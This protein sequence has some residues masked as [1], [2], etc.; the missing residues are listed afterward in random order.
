MPQGVRIGTT[1]LK[2]PIEAMAGEVVLL[3]KK[4]GYRDETFA[5]PADHD[6]AQTLTLRK[7]AVPAQPPAGKD[8]FFTKTPAPPSTQTLDPFAKPKN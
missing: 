5:M 1:P 6:G 4:K 3:M 2:H 7:L 8:D